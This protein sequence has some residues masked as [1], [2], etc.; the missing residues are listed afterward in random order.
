MDTSRSLSIMLGTNGMFLGIC[1]LMVNFGARFI[2]SDMS[3]TQEY[4]LKLPIVKAFILFCMCFLTTRDVRIS[5]VLTTAFYLTSQALLNEN[6]QFNV[7]P[8]FIKQQIHQREL[9]KSPLPL[10][11]P[12]SQS[13]SHQSLFNPIPKKDQSQQTE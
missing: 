12:L 13:Q 10:P 1:S 6:S 8:S 11:F 2:I 4:L 9:K 7:I 3:N 5:I